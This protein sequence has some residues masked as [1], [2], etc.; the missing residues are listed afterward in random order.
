MDGYP[1]PLDFER[2][3]LT[4]VTKGN[5]RG[6]WRLIASAARWSPHAG[7][8]DRFVLAP[9][10]MAGDVYGAGMLPLDPPYGFQIAASRAAF[11]HARFRK[12]PPEPQFIG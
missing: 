8:H 4:W 9:R 6:R 11:H 1:P 3:N 2:A 12:R 5:S 7:E 10:I